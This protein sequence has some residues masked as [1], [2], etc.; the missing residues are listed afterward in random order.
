MDDIDRQFPYPRYL[1]VPFIFW[2]DGTPEPP[3]WAQFK[4]DY[5][6]WVVFRGWFVP[7][8]PAELEPE[9]PA[10]PGGLSYA[11]ATRLF[12]AACHSASAHAQPELQRAVPNTTAAGAA[13]GGVGRRGRRS[14]KVFSVNRRGRIDHGYRG[15]SDPRGRSRTG[16]RGACARD[17]GRRR[18]GNGAC[19]DCG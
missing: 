7:E 13:S 1:K 5:P 19:P 16:P 2:A 9:Q 17:C 8:P 10:L 18:H 6:G 14:A 12:V 15:K 3:E 11:E 4:R